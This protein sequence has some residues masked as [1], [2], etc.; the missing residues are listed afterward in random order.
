MVKEVSYPVFL[1]CKD[2]THVQACGSKADLQ[3]QLEAIDV[4]NEEYEGWDD[5]GFRVVL[6][7]TNPESIRSLE[8]ERSGDCAVKDEA[9]KAFADFATAEG[10]SFAMPSKAADLLETYESLA[11]EVRLV[12]DKR[13]WY[14]KLLGR[15]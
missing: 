5:Q 8:V 15:V 12:R 10:T 14:K 13:P 4:E 11:R 9:L 2:D 3:R 7:L 6:R 1:R